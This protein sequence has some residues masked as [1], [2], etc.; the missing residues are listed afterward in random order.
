MC[1]K[2]PHRKNTKSKIVCV[3]LPCYVFLSPKILSTG[4]L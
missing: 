4:Y 2:C 1:R 3:F